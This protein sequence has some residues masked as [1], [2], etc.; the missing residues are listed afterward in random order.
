MNIK[1]P[2]CKKTFRDTPVEGSAQCPKC[3][4]FFNV[5]SK[6]I[7]L[8]LTMEVV[9]NTEGTNTD[10]LIDRLDLAASNIINNGVITGDSMA[11]LETFNWSVKK[12]K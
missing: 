8:K 11:I 7:T 3:E 2:F 5:P 10:S 12:E 1:C 9:I 4:E 6:Q